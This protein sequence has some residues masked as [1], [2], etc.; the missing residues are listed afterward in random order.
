MLEGHHNSLENYMWQEGNQ[1]VYSI[2]SK[3][4]MSL[5]KNRDAQF[6]FTF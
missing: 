5:T 6:I 2:K 4:E 3:I 1:E